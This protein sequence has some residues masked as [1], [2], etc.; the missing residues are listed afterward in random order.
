LSIVV[1]AMAVAHWIEAQTG[2]S[3]K[4]FV[5]TACRYRTVRIKGGNQTLTAA[6]PLPDDPRDALLKS[7]AAVC[8]KLSQ[9][10]KSWGT[11]HAVG[12]GL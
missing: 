4:K 12:V 2:W 10:G 11:P 6:D 9:V 5:R 1:A 3:I 7:A 8:T